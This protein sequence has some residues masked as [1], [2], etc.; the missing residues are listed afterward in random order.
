MINL[1]SIMCLVGLAVSTNAFSEELE[2]TT[3]KDGNLK[4]NVLSVMSA[5][6]EYKENFG[7][8]IAGALKGFPVAT[9]YDEQGRSILS[10]TVAGGGN[11][12]NVSSYSYLFKYDGNKMTKYVI[13]TLTKEGTFDQLNGTI[14]TANGSFESLMGTLPQYSSGI[15]LYRVGEYEYEGNILT[16]YTLKDGRSNILGKYVA[17]KQDNGSYKWSYYAKDGSSIDNGILTYNKWGLAS[18]TAESEGQFSRKLEFTLPAPG[19]YTYDVKGNLTEH[20]KKSESKRYAYNDKGD[21][22]K[23]SKKVYK[24]WSAVNFYENYVYDDHG[25]W[26]SRTKGYDVGKPTIIEKRVIVYADSKEDLAQKATA[27]IQAVEPIVMNVK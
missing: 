20:V 26:I 21:Q 3:L 25:N 18:K 9:F 4:G 8:P 22:T 19:T 2:P 13:N 24:D 15:Y 1:K 7:D 6:Y 27:L 23:E 16:S 17:K 5:T 14:N 10:R 11:S 12:Y